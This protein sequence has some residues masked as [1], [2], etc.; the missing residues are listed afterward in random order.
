[1]PVE[2]FVLNTEITTYINEGVQILHE[3]LVRAHEADY[4]EK[5]A[6]FTLDSSGEA[7]LPTDFMKVY[8]VELSDTSGGKRTLLP[9][10][11]AERNAL[12]SAPFSSTRAPRYKLSA[13]KLRV[14]P[15]ASVSG[16]T[17]TIW[18]APV[19]T[20]YTSDTSSNV[21]FLNGW[22]RYVVVY[23]A[24]QCLLKEES[25][26]R[27]LEN[28]LAMMDKQLDEAISNRDAGH[29]NHAVDVE[30]INDWE[31]WTL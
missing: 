17:G 26:T 3:K 6:S 24:I 7:T 1:M 4:T 25:D 28:M 19:A 8:G 10:K 30:N 29:S 15:A 5:S 16:K 13:G 12:S 11:R 14:L 21:D 27:P 9:Y 20:L 22:E 2:G 31:F 23:A 18:Y